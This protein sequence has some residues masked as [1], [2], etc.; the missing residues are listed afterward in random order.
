MRSEVDAVLGGR[1]PTFH[2]IP[3]LVYLRQVIDETLRLRPPVAM[4]ARNALADADLGGY[5]VRTSDLVIPFFWAVHRHP[6]FWSTPAKFDPERFSADASK[7]RNSWS[8]LPFSA[9]PR[10]CIGNMFSLIETVLLLAQLLQRFDF[11]VRDCSQ[12]KPNSVGTVRPSKPV[13]VKFAARRR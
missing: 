7:G 10:I 6:D 4:V 11:E 8:Y 13:R 3:K 9:G 5:Q 12:V 2:D 1:E